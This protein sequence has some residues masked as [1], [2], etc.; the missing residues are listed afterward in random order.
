[1]CMSVL[2]VHAP[3]AHLVSMELKRVSTGSLELESHMV[4]SHC[5]DGGN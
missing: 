1:M 2:L 4:V 3:C 5:V